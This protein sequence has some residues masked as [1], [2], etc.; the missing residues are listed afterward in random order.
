M[1]PNGT[2]FT[3]RST[4]TWC[5]CWCCWAGQVPA[6][7]SW[8]SRLPGRWWQLSLFLNAAHNGLKYSKNTKGMKQ[9]DTNHHHNLLSLTLPYLGLLPQP[10]LCCHQLPGLTHALQRPVPLWL[11]SPPLQPRALLHPAPAA[12]QPLGGD[13]CFLCCLLSRC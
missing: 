4:A 9:G 2:D 6:P 13:C 7:F 3:Q 11:P 8:C 1:N 5:T 12:S 10:Q